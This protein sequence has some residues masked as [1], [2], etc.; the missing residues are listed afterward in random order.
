MAEKENNKEE[1]NKKEN[2]KKE[3]SKKCNNKKGSNKKTSPVIITEQEKNSHID[4]YDIK[5]DILKIMIDKAVNNKLLKE[6]NKKILKYI[7]RKLEQN[8]SP[9]SVDNR[10]YSLYKTIKKQVDDYLMF[11]EI[12]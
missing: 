4:L 5:Q 2:N 8:T 11:C 3:N 10:I 6:N 9:N 7:E 12:D 1:N